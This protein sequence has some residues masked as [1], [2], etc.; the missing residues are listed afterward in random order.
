[1]SWFPE[2]TMAAFYPSQDFGYGATVYVNLT[3]NGAELAKS[4]FSVRPLPTFIQGFVID[5]DMNPVEGITVTL[6]EINRSVTTN[7]DGAFGFGFGQPAEKDIPPGMYT[8]VINQGRKNRN[9]SELSF[10]INVIEGRLNDAG[11]FRL[12]SLKDAAF[13]RVVS[14]QADIRLDRGNITLN[15]E[16]ADLT[17]PDGR[18]AGDVAVNYIPLGKL[19]H[20][21][22]N[23]AVP[24]GCYMVQPPG[25]DVNGHPSVTLKLPEINGD[26]QYMNVIQDRVVLLGFSP[27]AMMIV[28]VGVGLINK[29]AHTITSEGALTLKNL[30]YIGYMFVGEDIKTTLEDYAKGLVDLNQLINALASR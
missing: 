24:M 30:D 1:M 26:Y 11:M 9:R 10:K 16:N 22:L 27:D 13:G 29:T 6:A 17:F 25:I 21:F 23:Y 15:L 4:V 3:Y 18:N 7:G 12:P 8:V 14:G 20:S 19:P 28:P 2:N 5:E